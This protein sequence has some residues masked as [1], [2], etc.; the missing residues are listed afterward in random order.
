MKVIMPKPNTLN[1]LEA[2]IRSAN[3]VLQRIEEWKRQNGIE[4]KH[5]PDSINGIMSERLAKILLKE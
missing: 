5:D 2:A 3:Q 1:E 4:I